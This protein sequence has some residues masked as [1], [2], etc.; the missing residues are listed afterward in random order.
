MTKE[1][2]CDDCNSGFTTYM[3]LSLTLTWNASPACLEY[4]V[5]SQFDS[6]KL[7]LGW[8]GGWFSFEFNDRSSSALANQ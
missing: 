3:T 8:V 5:K 4:S 6:E 7:L 1:A 2:T